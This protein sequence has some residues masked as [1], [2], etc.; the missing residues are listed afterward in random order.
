MPLF[1][2]PNTAQP[3]ELHKL[4][5]GYDNQATVRE[6]SLRIDTGSLVAVVG[7]N[8]AG[9]STL[10]R[11]LAGELQ[12]ISGRLTGLA[13]QRIACLPQRAA[14]DRSFPIDLRDMVAMGL[15]HRVGALGRFTAAHRL[16][17]TE[18]LAQ[19]GLE[20][21]EKRAL[22]TLSGGQLQRAL[23]ARLILQDAQ[24]VLLDEPFA[25]VDNRTTTDLL[26]LLHHWQGE[27]KT[28]VAALHDLSQVHRHFPLTLSLS[29]AQATFGPTDRVL[30]APNRTPTPWLDHPAETEAVSGEAF[31]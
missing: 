25:A 12:P 9:K 17:C 22:D 1:N 6:A 3:I 21:L 18:A 7:P 16:L 11:A 30:G 4:T 28:V 15:W 26:A 10:I 19:V 20:G 2:E 27:G 8:G 14:L 23:F 29:R 13:G 24:V 5:L 31:A